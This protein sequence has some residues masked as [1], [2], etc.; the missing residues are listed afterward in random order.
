MNIS[1]IVFSVILDVSNFNISLPFAANSASDMVEI[2]AG[3]SFLWI[4]PNSSIST[5]SLGIEVSFD[6]LSTEVSWLTLLPPILF[7]IFA[8]L[9]C[10][11]SALLK[12]ISP[13][14]NSPRLLSSS[15]L[16]TFS[17]ELYAPR[18]AAWFIYSGMLSVPT[19]F[20]NSSL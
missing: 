14:A 12:P 2:P 5:T 13:I 3:T 8:S 9:C 1:E 18:S 6:K 20:V 15:P 17:C 11:N 10:T 16:S 19:V 7:L 4:C